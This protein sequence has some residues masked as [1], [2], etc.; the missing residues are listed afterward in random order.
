MEEITNGTGT[1]RVVITMTDIEKAIA[2]YKSMAA[3]KETNMKIAEQE[4]NKHK[5]EVY[6]AEVTLLNSIIYNLEKVL[7]NGKSIF[8]KLKNE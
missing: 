3:K 7:E 4:G 2:T 8:F 5:A 6:F 1:E